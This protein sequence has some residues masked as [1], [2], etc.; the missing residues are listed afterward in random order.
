MQVF[1][2]KEPHL[3]EAASIEE[4]QFWLKRLNNSG[5]PSRP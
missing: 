1:F 3:L 2:N 5:A 4:A